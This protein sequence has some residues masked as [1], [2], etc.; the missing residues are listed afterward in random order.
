MCMSRVLTWLSLAADLLSAV[1]H[2]LLTVCGCLVCRWDHARIVAWLMCKVDKAQAALALACPQ[3]L[4]TSDQAARRYAAGTLCEYLS[5]E[6]AACVMAH[7]EHLETP[8]ACTPAVTTTKR[9][10]P[11]PVEAQ[12]GSKV[13]LHAC[14]VSLSALALF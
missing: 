5:A 12:S 13:Q 6:W 10:C 14:A 11:D 4:P 7:F 9:S 3:S 2:A 8:A 1:L